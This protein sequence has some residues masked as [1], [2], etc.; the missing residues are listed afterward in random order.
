MDLD[1]GL[2]WHILSSKHRE[3]TYKTVTEAG[4][5][6][7]YLYGAGRRVWVYLEE[8][9]KEYGEVPTLAL[10]Q[11]RIGFE[12]DPQEFEGTSLKFFINEIQNRKLT[13]LVRDG[14]E[15]VVELLEG[16]KPN[17]AF[18]E[19]Q[20][21]IKTVLDA[22]A[23]ESKITTLFAL[24]ERVLEIYD[25]MKR[26]ERGISSPWPS[27]DKITLGW[28]PEDLI[29]ICARLGVGKSQSLILMART[30]WKEGKRV[31][32]V[33]TEMSQLK[34]AQRF[35]A[36][37]LHLSYRDLREGMLGDLTEEKF[38]EGVRNLQKQDGIYLIGGDFD[39]TIDSI[40]AVVEECHPDLILVDGL[41]LIRA[42][43]NDRR[44]MV[45]NA[46][47]DMK[48]LAKRK[49]IP[50][51]CTSQLNR[52]VRKNATSAGAENIGVTDVIG[53]DADYIFAFLQ[54]ED[55]RLEKKMKVQPLKMREG[56]GEEFMV[57]WDWDT[58]NFSEVADPDDEFKD[59]EFDKE[60]P[61]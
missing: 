40:S 42:G 1:R 39:I 22:K 30:A 59:G 15:K 38:K 32:F 52:E 18:S 11:E 33:S 44:E 16:H 27:M 53:W 47:D 54:S 5:N 6:D 12:V 43:G 51:V 17:E 7:A 2:L 21:T 25:R 48:R 49:M 14:T 45:S 4:I 20:G 29:V 9:G 24:G 41:Y 35:F 13:N 46:I 36:I 31:L 50:V 37:E 61:F 58:P 60:V 3:K 19:L 28:W 26:G 57:N 55:M 23:N 10:V 8:Y 56:D 34:L